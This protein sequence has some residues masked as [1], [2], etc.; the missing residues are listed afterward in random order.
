MSPID[1]GE[2]IESALEGGV[3]ELTLNRPEA[4]NPLSLKMAAELDAAIAE[5]A[6]DPEVRAVLLRGAGR[7]FCSGADLGGGD[8]SATPEGRPDVLTGLRERYNPLILALRRLPKPVVAAVGG[9]AAGV[10][11]SLALACDQIVAAESSYFLLAFANIGLTVDGGASALLPARVGIA[12]ATEMAMLAERVPAPRALEWGLINRVVA[13]DRLVAEASELAGRL[14]VGPTLSYAATKELLNA[15][16]YPD[17]EAQLDR[18][19]L[20]QQRQA[21]SSDFVAGVAAFFEKRKPEFEG[22]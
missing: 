4:L 1:G 7:A 8:I 15:H 17:L 3:L 10:G 13:D 21:E 6:T 11:C 14:A 16:A 12:R 22:Y 2:Q 5:A 20:A 9:A 19:A 18:E